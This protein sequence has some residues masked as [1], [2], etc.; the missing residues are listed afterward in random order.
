MKPVVL[1]ILDGW[2]WRTE[3][4]GNAILSAKTPCWD[5]LWKRYPHAFLVTSGA[6][7]GLPPNTIGNS[8]VGHLNI[9]AGRV[10]LQ[11]LLRINRAIADRSFFTKSIFLDCCEAVQK[12]G[13]A[14]H[15][16]GLCSDA[17]VHSHL[18]H[19]DAL[20]DLAKRQKVERV[21]IHA[22][23]DGRDSSPHAGE[24]YL[25]RVA[26]KCRKVGNACVATVSGRYYAM[27]RDQRWDRTEK[28]WRALV[29][30][31]GEK[32]SSAEAVLH[33]SYAAGVTDEF[34]LPHVIVDAAA[35]PLAT[36]QSG[37]A[38]IFWNFR[39]DRARQ[40]TRALAFA[41]FREFQRSIVPNLSQFVML[42][43]YDETYQLPIAFPSEHLEHV[44]GKV[45]AAHGLKQLRIAETEKYAHVTYFFNGGEETPFAGED[46]CLIPSPRD[47][48]TY[49]QKPEMSAR[50][51]TN[52]L[53]KKLDE[54]TYDVVILNFANPD[55]VGHTGDLK[56]ATR[57]VEVVDACL[58]KVVAR[59]QQQGGGLIITADHGN[60]EEMIDDQGRP[61]TSHTFNPVPLVYVSA[62][63][64]RARLADQGRLCD[65]APTLLA[66]LNLRQPPEMTGKSLLLS[67]NA[68]R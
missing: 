64:Q 51:V 2:G 57:A 50:Q 15:L 29:L 17:G 9:G 37:D 44:L 16:I 56:A 55:M 52:E 41:D 49:D 18:D 6:S 23:T 4:K 7:V 59:V 53:L 12:S 58:A 35:A 30:G 28:A 42:T 14:L 26:K 46:R 31:E 38:V 48:A 33:Q 34:I 45:L 8:E 65:I 20:L 1:V 32:A 3:K 61:H 10:V 11:D 66:L 39:A 25:N 43:E 68:S 13:G 5:E 54:G 47:V 60:C 62:A 22:I 19:L 63:A 24:A 27:D 67:D 40:L 21:F 36:L